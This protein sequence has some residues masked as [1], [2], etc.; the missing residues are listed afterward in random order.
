LDISRLDLGKTKVKWHTVDVNRLIETLARDRAL[1]FADHGLNLRVETCAQAPPVQG[2]PQL[3]EQV[4]TNLLTNALN[5]T[6][7]G[8]CVC[9]RTK[10]VDTGDDRWVTVEVED[11]GPGIP[12]AEQ[13]HLF[14]RF[15]RGSSSQTTN[16]P[17][18]GL[19]L[20]IS[21]EIMDLHAGRITVSSV[22]ESGTTFTIWLHVNGKQE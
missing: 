18:T 1:L 20:A 8:G 10:T 5:Y 11:T 22:L 9:L 2:D 14:E 21:K 16:T 3:L 4:L 17:G 15:Y 7:E 6:P 12:R 19:G 13:A